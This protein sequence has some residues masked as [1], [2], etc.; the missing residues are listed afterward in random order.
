V[1]TITGLSL[2]ISLLVDHRGF[3]MIMVDR[4]NGMRVCCS[5]PKGTGGI[6]MQPD[7][8]STHWRSAKEV[9]AGADLYKSGF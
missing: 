5:S 9:R 1:K 8:M 2:G 3:D 6:C 7:L 4:R